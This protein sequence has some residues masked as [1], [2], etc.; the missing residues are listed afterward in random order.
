VI[1]HLELGFG[2]MGFTR[3]RKLDNPPLIWVLKNVTMRNPIL[4]LT[5][6]TMNG[7][8]YTPL[9]PANKN[10]C[11]ILGQRGAKTY[12]CKKMLEVEIHE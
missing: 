6:T 1:L 5:S 9:L 12:V 3:N 7:P 10:I 4:T 8:C 11:E 2:S